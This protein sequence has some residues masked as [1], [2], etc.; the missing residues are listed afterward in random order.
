MRHLL[1]LPLSLLLGCPSASSNADD[2]DATDALDDDDATPECDAFG[3]E[4]GDCPPEFELPSTAGGQ[5][6][7]GDFVGE[8]VIVLG[9]SNW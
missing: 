5:V 9:T 4:P 6:A 8:R 7:L 1:L 3:L 2:D